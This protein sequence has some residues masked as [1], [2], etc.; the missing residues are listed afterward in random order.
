LCQNPLVAQGGETVDRPWHHG[1]DSGEAQGRA[2]PGLLLVFSDGKPH[3]TPIPLGGEPLAIG[4][5]PVGSIVIDDAALSRRHAEVAFANGQWQIRDLGSR[6]GTAVDA[7]PLTQPLASETARLL[8]C[9]D[10]LFL[11]CAD[12]R[13]FVRAR[14]EVLDDAVVGPRLRRTWDEVASVAARRDNLHITGETGA[15]K[16]LA[17]RHF[18]R[19]GPAREGPFVAVNCATIP[20]AIAERLLFGARR[21]AYSGADT[22]SEGYLQAA[23]GGTLF[24]DEVAELEPAVQAKLLRVLETREVLQLGATRPTRIDLRICSAT[25]GGLQARV[26]EGRFREDLYFRLGRP[27]V[28]VLPLRERAEEIP[29]LI[30]LALAGATAHVSLI[31]RALS[32]TWPGNVREILGEMK[33][34]ARRASKLG[35]A[36]VEARHLD[37][38]STLVPTEEVAPD[39]APRH[40]GP[41]VEPP[42]RE[43]LQAAL[44][45]NQGNISRAARALGVHRTQLRRWMERYQKEK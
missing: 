35:S 4:R 6:N 16:E 41:P 26:S 14:V 5:G 20:T 38:S 12:L 29:Y 15:G 45:E 17:A 44:D 43:V 32:H 28:R 18:H 37:E 40:R 31:E 30:N 23:T 33:E 39:D 8:R 21:G 27:E 2:L 9:G 3:L 10:T 13:P 42:P 11:L 36:L 19:A 34:A 22:N 7:R 1:H 25:H 24:L